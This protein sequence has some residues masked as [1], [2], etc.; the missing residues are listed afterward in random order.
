MKLKDFSLKVFLLPGV[1]AMTVL[2]AACTPAETTPRVWIDYP[3]DGTRFDKPG[4]MTITAHA[5]A[6]AGIGYIIFSVNNVPFYQQEPGVEGAPFSD[7]EIPWSPA[8]NGSYSLDVAM[9]DING[10]YGGSAS[11]RVQIGA[12]ELDDPTT[13]P[14]DI[15]VTPVITDTPT[16]PPDMPTA[17]Y[18]PTV[19]LTV[20]API[21]ISFYADQISISPGECV[22]LSWTVENADEVL[23]DNSQ[24]TASGTSQACPSSTHEYVLSATRGQQ[25]RYQQITITVNAPSDT[26]PPP[27]PQPMV[28]SNGLHIA[29]KASQTLVWMPV[30]DPSGISGYDVELLKNVSGSWQ[31]VKSWNNVSGKQ[32]TA[33]VDCGLEYRWRVRAVG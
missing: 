15:T 32:V 25:Y 7:F 19:T 4:A 3:K 22:Q 21:T 33:S 13:V 30:T 27:V 11:S 18:T 5:A 26:T 16:P 8:E 10:N 9:Y 14:M 20:A 17:T 31:S 1:L 24:V 6:P 28:P 2:L 29:C 23:L 12:P